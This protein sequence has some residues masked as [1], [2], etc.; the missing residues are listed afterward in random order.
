MDF[1][2]RVLSGLSACGATP[3]DGTVA[4]NLK[5]AA[6]RLES[7]EGQLKAAL[8]KQ[9]VL[10]ADETG[11]KVNAKMHWLHVVSNVNF[12][13]LDKAALSWIERHVLSRT[14]PHGPVRLPGLSAYT[15]IMLNAGLRLWKTSA[16]STPLRA[17]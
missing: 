11:S 17:S 14:A 4:L 16:Y 9:T 5:L 8:L 6:Q 7:F 13:V 15:D 1:A 12:T 3:S 2:N 10:N